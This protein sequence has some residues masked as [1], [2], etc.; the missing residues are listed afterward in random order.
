M[1]LAL[2]RQEEQG[3][4]REQVGRPLSLFFKCN[5]SQAH[6]LT[7]YDLGEYPCHPFLGS[8]QYYT[9]SKIGEFRNE[10]MCG[11]VSSKVHLILNYAMCYHCQ[12]LMINDCF[13]FGME[14][15]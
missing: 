7:S 5:V 4:E 3:R 8:S 2:G 12:I 14:Q 9:V 11:Q 10:Y 15:L 6:K 13:S 1:A